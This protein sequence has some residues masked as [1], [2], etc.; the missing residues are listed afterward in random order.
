LTL[1]A[2]TGVISGTPTAS[3]SPATTLTFRVNDANGCQGTQ[4][5]TLQICPVVTLAPASLPTPTVGTAY[6]QT[7]TASGGTAPYTY[8]L[9]S[10]ARLG[11]AEQCRRSERHAPQH[12][13]S[14]LHAEGHGHQRL[15]WHAQLHPRSCLPHHLNHA[16]STRSR[17][18]GHGLLADSHRFR[19][20]RSL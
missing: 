6:S 11:H 5:V 16:R 19:R 13:R 17:H 2:S 20:H 14:N 15:R 18:R 8:T 7:I 3:A 1:N 10:P 4:S 9:S 12:H